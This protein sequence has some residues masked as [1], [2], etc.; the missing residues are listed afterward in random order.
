MIRLRRK[1]PKCKGHKPCSKCAKRAWLTYERASVGKTMG[2]RL[3]VAELQ[4]RILSLFTWGNLIENMSKAGEYPDFDRAGWR[5]F[6][7]FK[8][9][10]HQFIGPGFVYTYYTLEEGRP[11][12][13]L[14]LWARENSKQPIV[15]KFRRRS[16][17]NELARLQNA[18]AAWWKR[19]KEAGVPLQGDGPAPVRVPGARPDIVPGAPGRP[20]L[21]PALSPR[22]K[23]AIGAVGALALLGMLAPYAQ[24]A[25][26]MRKRV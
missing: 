12:R 24:I 14:E 23:L 5:D 18:T 15:L 2:E 13:G 1:D 16:I 20:G 10:S 4:G 21:L 7:A 17:E 8:L 19:A 22:A 25:A 6:W 26:S 9:P 3:G 11:A